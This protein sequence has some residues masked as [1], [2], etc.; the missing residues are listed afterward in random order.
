MKKYYS[1]LFPLF[2]LFG[3]VVVLFILSHFHKASKKGLNKK[4]IVERAIKKDYPFPAHYSAK[5]TNY[6]FDSKQDDKFLNF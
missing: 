5:E 1:L 2:N 3:I 6:K 4:Q